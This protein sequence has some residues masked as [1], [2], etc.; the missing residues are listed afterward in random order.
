MGGWLFGFANLSSHDLPL[1]SCVYL[2]RISR[3][4]GWQSQCS[5][6]WIKGGEKSE[7]EEAGNLWICD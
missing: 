6:N 4:Y 2:T 5:R 3:H 1:F 7:K